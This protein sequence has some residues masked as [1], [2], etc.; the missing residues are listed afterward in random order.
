MSLGAVTP[1]AGTPV[2]D[3]SVLFDVAVDPD[4]G[5]LFAVWQD[6]RF[7]GFDEIAFSEST[8]GGFTWS[9]P[10][11]INQTPASTNPLREQAFLPS[12]A[13]NADGVVGVT[14]YDFRNDDDTGELADHWFISCAVSCSNPTSWGGEARLTDDSFD[15][16]Q[17][18]FANGL[19]LG[20]YVGLASD[21]DSFVAFFQQSSAADPADGFFRRVTP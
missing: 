1:D 17:A 6:A 11:I 10:I 15:Y 13:V 4:N 12:V 2:R 7:S 5:N 20:D 16:S 14:Y 9:T 18:P 8:D 19:F 21:G 3:A